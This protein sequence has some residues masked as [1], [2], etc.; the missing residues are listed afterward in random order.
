MNVSF[1]NSSAEMARFCAADPRWADVVRR[2][3]DDLR[4]LRDHFSD[5]TDLLCGWGHNF[6]CPR[7][8][9]QLTLDFLE[10]LRP[11]RT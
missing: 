5:E 2:V 6:V 3:E 4:D 7:C 1:C 9:A 11:G 10:P 8:A